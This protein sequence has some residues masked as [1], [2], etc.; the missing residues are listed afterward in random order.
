MTRDVFGGLT[1]FSAFLIS[2]VLCAQAD[3]HAVKSI[4]KTTALI[5]EAG[6]ANGALKN[7]ESGNV[8]FPFAQFKALATVRVV[9]QSESYATMGRAPAPET[10]P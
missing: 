3:G 6:L 10:Y 9:Y 8:N 2:T 5:P 7:G 4:G 1:V